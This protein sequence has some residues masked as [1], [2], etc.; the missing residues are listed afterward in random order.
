MDERVYSVREV[1]QLYGVSEALVNNWIRS[2]QLKAIAVDNLHADRRYYNGIP[3][4]Q[5]WGVGITESEL[6]RFTPNLS[7]RT[8]QLLEA[9]NRRLKTEHNKYLDWLDKREQD[10]YEEIEFVNKMRDYLKE[11]EPYQ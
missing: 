8:I 1:A 9:K 10:L 6:N 3:V 2:G 4:F 11:I 5:H 7:Y